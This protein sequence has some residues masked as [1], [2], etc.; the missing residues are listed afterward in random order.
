[1]FKPYFKLGGGK[2]R[3][4]VVIAVNQKARCRNPDGPVAQP[5]YPACDRSISS[6]SGLRWRCRRALQSPPSAW[7]RSLSGSGVSSASRE[8][9]TVS[10]ASR[11][12]RWCPRF[13]RLKARR[14]ALVRSIL[15][16]QVGRQVGD[17]AEGGQSTIAGFLHRGSCRGIRSLHLE[18]EGFFRRHARQQDTDCVGQ[19]K[20]HGCECLG[21]PC[22]CSLVDANVNHLR[23]S[24]VSQI[25][26]TG[27][28]EGRG[29][30]K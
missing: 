30:H 18:R 23:C 4:M 6:K 21:G 20:T 26:L 22:L 12:R 16:L 24:L 15:R 13:S 11:S 9:T 17:I 14:K 28:G 8:T 5:Q 1:M 19:G 10:T 3:G 29:I 7:S 27:Q 25:R 2:A